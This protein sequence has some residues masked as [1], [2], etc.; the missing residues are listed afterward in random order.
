MYIYNAS[1]SPPVT[2]HPRANIIKMAQCRGNAK[3]CTQARFSQA[4]QTTRRIFWRLQ[5]KMF[6]AHFS[7]TKP[8]Y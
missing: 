2:R 6:N 4:P 1:T 8:I 7:G 5:V 3:L